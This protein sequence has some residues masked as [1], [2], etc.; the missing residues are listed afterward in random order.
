MP[1]SLPQQ[2]ELL[3]EQTKLSATSEHQETRQ[4][5]GEGLSVATDVEDCP[6]CLSVWNKE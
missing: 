3:S 5:Q 1:E 4:E 6:L 2:Q